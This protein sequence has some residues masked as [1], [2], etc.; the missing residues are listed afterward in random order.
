MIYCW[1]IFYLLIEGCLAQ[2][3]YDPGYVVSWRGD[4]RYSNSIMAPY[5]II[6]DTL[7]SDELPA[8]FRTP[9]FAKSVDHNGVRLDGFYDLKISGSNQ[10]SQGQLEAIVEYLIRHYHVKRE[11]IAVVD[12]REEPHGLINGDAVTFYY[13]PLYTLKNKS[14]DEVLVSDRQRINQV[15]GMP[16]IILNKMPVSDTGMPRNKKPMIMP[17]KSAMTEQE[18]ATMV[19][20]QYIRIPVTDHFRPDH[21]DVDQFLDFVEKLPPGAWLHFKC[22]GGRGRTTT[23]MLMYDMLKNPSLPKEEFAKRQVLIHGTDLS[24]I[25]ISGKKKWK[26]FL[27]RERFHFVERFYEYLHAADGYGYQKWS[28]WVVIHYPGMADETYQTDIE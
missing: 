3:S 11:N 8:R 25:P 19:G 28:Q 18:L 24:M 15:R 6:L 16:Y 5:D 10:F 4:S 27:S 26:W 14:P 22:R 1:L 13:G 23:F 21:N 9:H 17:V 7:N 20:V 12:L 2:V